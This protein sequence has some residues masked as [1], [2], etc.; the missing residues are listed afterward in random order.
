VHKLPSLKIITTTVLIVLCFTSSVY[1]EET[2]KPVLQPT[3]TVT[4]QADNTKPKTDLAEDTEEATGNTLIAAT[5]QP[6]LIQQEQGTSYEPP[7]NNGT[8][9]NGAESKQATE[10]KPHDTDSE[11]N[12]G[13]TPQPPLT[14]PQVKPSY[15]PKAAEDKTESTAS[16]D[17]ESAP[18]QTSEQIIQEVVATEPVPDEAIETDEQAGD[19]SAET[20]DKETEEEEKQTKKKMDRNLSGISKR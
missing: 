6:P 7:I 9:D 2:D 1:A 16:D 8:E 13:N 5:P 19:T 17:S 15:E 18:D 12:I 3:K 4:A 20:T 11:R 14:E 10:D